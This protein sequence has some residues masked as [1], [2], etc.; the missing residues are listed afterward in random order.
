[1]SIDQIF[2]LSVIAGA[3]LIFAA[4]LA[5]GDYQTRHITHRPSTHRPSTHRPRAAELRSPP[6]RAVSTLQN[7]VTAAHAAAQS[8]QKANVVELAP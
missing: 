7:T 8:R 4:V 6:A 3:F 5:W 2:F 1:M